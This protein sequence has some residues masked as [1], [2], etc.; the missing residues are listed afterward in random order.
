MS[1][2]PADIGRE[3]LTDVSPGRRAG[4]LS[5][6]GPARMVGCPACLKPLE[7]Y[8]PQKRR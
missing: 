7:P 5:G 1:T 8:S 2:D 6:A 4:S 3:H